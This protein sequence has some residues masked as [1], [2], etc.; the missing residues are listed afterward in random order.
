[1]FVDDERVVGTSEELTWQAA[2]TLDVEQS[3]LGIQDVAH[4]VR[5]CSQ[6]P[7]AWLCLVIYM[8][9]KLGCMI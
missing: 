1:M 4:K 6:T 2:H 5:S 9:D 8:V 3:Y 7:G